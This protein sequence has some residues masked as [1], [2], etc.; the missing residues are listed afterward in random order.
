MS[1]EMRGWSPCEAHVVQ[2]AFVLSHRT[3]RAVAAKTAEPFF[4]PGGK[5]WLGVRIGQDR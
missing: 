5:L 1:V 3:T 4:A 2:L